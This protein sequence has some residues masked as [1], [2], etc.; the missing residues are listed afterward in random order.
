ML[1]ITASKIFGQQYYPKG[2]PPKWQFEIAPNIWLPWIKG[3]VGVDG[4][5]KDLEGTITATSADLLSNLKMAYA[6]NA[7]IS[8]K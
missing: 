3:Q 5:L 7:D 8:K 6:F 1:L 4:K 2:D